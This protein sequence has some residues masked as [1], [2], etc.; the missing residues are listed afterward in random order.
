M[1]GGILQE[2]G[3]LLYWG[4]LAASTIGP[5]SV[6]VLS[7]S[8]ADYGLELL[9]AVVVASVV[10]FTLQEGAAR[11]YIVSGLS[12]GEACRFHFGKDGKVP[13]I[14]YVMA[15]GI[16]VS[17]IVIECGQ[18]VGAM[19]ALLGGVLRGFADGV[20]ALYPADAPPPELP[21]VRCL[22][23]VCTHMH[24]PNTCTYIF[25]HVYLP[26]ICIYVQVQSLADVGPCVRII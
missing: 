17:N 3:N 14:S 8:G 6:I 9:W 13:P 21:T 25:V 1:G 16:V 18:S 4:M 7:K 24:V 11:L 10:A 12:F 20:R 2:I 19:A 26:C 5:G 15:V 23:D 22:A